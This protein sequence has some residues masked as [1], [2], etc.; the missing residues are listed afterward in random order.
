ML[1]FREQKRNFGF[2]TFW[3]NLD[4]LLR[5]KRTESDKIDNR[6][7]SLFEKLHYIIYENREDYDMTDSR[8]RL[9]QTLNHE[10]PDSVV[11]D[12]GSTAISGIH[13]NALASLRDA[14]GLEKRKVKI[15]EPLQLLGEVEE[16]LRE[17]LH[18]DCVDVSAGYNMFGFS[19]AGRKP[20]KLQNGLEV[21]VPTDFN[22][23]V[24]PDGR[25]Y[26]YPQGDTS[27]PASAV[28][29]KDGFFFDNITRGNS[30]C[31]E[32]GE[33][34]ARKDFEHDFGLLS[35]EQLRFMEERCN[36]YYNETKYGIVYSGAIASL[37]D[38]ALIPGPNVKH[39]QGIRE[40]TD[41]MMAGTLCPGYLHELFDMQTEYAIK[42]AELI[43]Q[44]CGDKIQAIYVSGADFGIQSGPYMSLDAYREFYKPY[45]TKINH[46]IHE[47]TG[48]KTFFHSC[49]AVADF[50]QDFHEA[51]VDILNPVQLSAAGMDGKMLKEKW[52]D[53]FVFWGGGVDT[54]KTLPFGTPEEV[55]R[56]VTERLKLFSKG[57]GF[58]FNTVHNIQANVPIE[59][60]CAMFQALD[61]FRIKEKKK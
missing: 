18:L 15:C 8:E 19:N 44:A 45:H 54:Q 20:W 7:L 32:D 58:V 25:T 57:G 11:V 60:I 40:L 10:E 48:W 23:T 43:Y 41:F 47:H 30:G 4:I 31:P 52:G 1:F 6:H 37:G 5:K 29:P 49:G 61:N 28:M 13:A 42:N 39:P 14:L 56:E 51:E 17:K 34:S 59:N 16:D 33:R 26:L 9:R 3:G 55:Y 35:E 27:A 12:M 46:W 22:T 38:F 24:G 50:L 2:H 53:K 21:D 36:Y